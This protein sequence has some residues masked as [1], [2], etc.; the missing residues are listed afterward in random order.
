MNWPLLVAGCFALLAT[1]IHGIVGDGLVRRAQ[2]TGQD[3]RL[4]FLVRVSWHFTTIAFAVPGIALI[5]MG[6]E[7]DS[8]AATGVAYVSGGLFT[9]WATFALVA[10]FLRGGARAWL[11]HPAPVLLSLAAGLIWWGVT[12][13]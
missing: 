10:S 12:R 1:A 11:K 2:I 6:V 4:K 7:P 9:L 5:T 3:S 13:L 8:T